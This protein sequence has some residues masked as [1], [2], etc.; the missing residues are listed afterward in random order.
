MLTLTSDCSSY[1]Y[2]LHLQWKYF[3]LMYWWG[4]HAALSTLLICHHDEKHFSFH[5]LRML[6]L[7]VWLII[8]ALMCLVRQFG[9]VVDFSGL[10]LLYF[11][12]DAVLKTYLLDLYS[13]RKYFI[14]ISLKEKK[15]SLCS[16]YCL[17]VLCQVWFDSACFI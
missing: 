7:S 17:I 11:C 3:V 10:W 8:Y 9:W 4:S 14:F 6:L 2:F 15:E 12:I 16:M 1:M 13:Y 5:V